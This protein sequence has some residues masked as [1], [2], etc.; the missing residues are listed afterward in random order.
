[1]KI[2]HNPIYLTGNEQRYIA[3]A[4]ASGSLCGDG[5]FT[6]YCEKWLEQTLQ[7]KRALLTHSCTASLEMA[8]QLCGIGPGDEVIMPSFTF[9]STA[10]A[11]VQRGAIPVFVDI[12]PHTCNIDPQCV[13]NA[14]GPKTRCI[15][16]VHYAGFPCAMAPIMEIA[17]RNSIKVIEDAAQGLLAKYDGKYLGSIGTLGCISFHESKNIQCGEGGALLINESSFVESA[18]IMREKGTN[19]AAFFRGQI[20]KYSWVEAGSSYIPSELNAAFLW[21]QLSAAQWV[22]EQ[23][24][25]HLFHYHQLLAPLAAQG[26]IDLPPLPEPYTGNGHIC[27]IITRSLSERTEL[28]K[29]LQDDG[30]RAFYHYI[31]LHSSKAGK[32]YGRA[33]S[34]LRITDHISDCLLRLPIYPHM[35]VEQVETVSRAV[36]KFYINDE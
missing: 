32:K 29:S 31:P 20:D 17:K 13:E 5:P 14:I 1:M 34:A 33:S 18:E 19:R 4:I 16:V 22:T 12:D 2:P 25:S 36:R 35:T 9:S 8:V 28:I 6:K 21:A 27:Y 23:K 11:V 30:I 15:I 3:E 24:I 7:C 26:Y 10:T